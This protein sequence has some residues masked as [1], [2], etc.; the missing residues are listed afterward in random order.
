MK[1]V[2]MWMSVS[3]NVYR[4]T[5]SSFTK[6]WLYLHAIFSLQL[7]TGDNFNSNSS[8]DVENLLRK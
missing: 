1:E 7:F 5:Q 2:L 8:N 6:R 4:T 3:L